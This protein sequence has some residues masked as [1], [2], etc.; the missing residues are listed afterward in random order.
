MSFLQQALK[1]FF[2]FELCVQFYIQLYFI[3]DFGI[4]DTSLLIF[5]EYVFSLL[6]YHDILLL[7]IV[8]ILDS[9]LIYINQGNCLFVIFCI[10]FMIKNIVRWVFYNYLLEK[11]RNG[12]QKLVCF[13][14]EKNK[15]NENLEEN[16]L[17]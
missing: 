16:L 1:W 11:D 6:V 10:E 14:L 7:V 4:N 2:L 5:F 13:L 3:F 9:Y 8:L 12:Y 15:E 17:V